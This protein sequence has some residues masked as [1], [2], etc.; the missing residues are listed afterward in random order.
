MIRARTTLLLW[1]AA[2]LFMAA[3]LLIAGAADAWLAPA[4][5]FAAEEGRLVIE[6]ERLLDCLPPGGSGYEPLQDGLRLYSNRDLLFRAETDGGERTPLFI[7]ARGTP[8]DGV[9]P[10][11]TL[12]V[13][14]EPEDGFFVTS[15]EWGLYRLELELPPGDHHFRISYAND[16]SRFPENRDLDISMIAL[17]APPPRWEEL[18]RWRRAS[19]IPAGRFSRQRFAEPEG[20]ALRLWQGGALAD[21]VFYPAEG[22]Q[23]VSL[24]AEAVDGS[25]GKLALLVDGEQVEQF[26]ITDDPN[27]SYRALFEAAA[28]LHRLELV[29]LQGE[30]LIRHLMTDGAAPLPPSTAEPLD[31]GAGL[32]IPARLLDVE[33]EGR[34]LEDGSRLLLS[35]GHVGR[36]ISNDAFRAI[37]LTLIAR[38]EL[39]GGEGPRLLLMVGDDQLASVGVN[40]LE[41]SP[42]PIELELEPGEHRI[43]LV[44]VNDRYVPNVCDRNLYIRELRLEEAP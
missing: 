29:S 36:A 4:P 32:V 41:F 6:G 27:R 16:R 26:D 13:D 7:V 30:I 19:V 3:C 22:M 23:K 5:R 18:V 34:L 38:G 39:C 10:L 12:C 31:L 8:L 11:L 44:Y 1:L 37:R 24:A 17:G 21:D 40:E 28:G 35:N 2:T 9:W 20:A 42:Y 14:R 15:R 33:A 43:R 25:S